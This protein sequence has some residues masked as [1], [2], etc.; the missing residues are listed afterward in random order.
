MSGK[1]KRLQSCRETIKDNP[2]ESNANFPQ[3]LSYQ[4]AHGAET[5]PLHRSYSHTH[6]HLHN[7]NIYFTSQAS[8]M[9]LPLFRSCFPKSSQGGSIFSLSSNLPLF[10]TLPSHQTRDCLFERVGVKA[11]VCVCV[12][13]WMCVASALPGGSV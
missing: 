3:K 2:K 12:C 13:A 4:P 7:P 5:I 8:E 11:C 6:T 9:T 1:K 10:S